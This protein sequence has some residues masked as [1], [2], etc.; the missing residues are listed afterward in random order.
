MSDTVNSLSDLRAEGAEL[1]L[2]PRL[3]TQPRRCASRKLDK[4]GRAYATGKRKD[5][6]ARVWLKPGTGKITVNGRDQEVY[7]AR[8]VLR[9]IINQPFQV[10]DREGQYDVV[11]RSRAAASPVRPVRCARHLEGADQLRARSCARGQEGRLPDPRQPRRRAQEVRQGEG[12]PQ[13]PVLEALANGPSTISPS[14][15]AIMPM[16]PCGSW[17][18]CGSASR[19]RMI[20]S[21]PWHCTTGASAYAARMKS[22]AA[23]AWIEVES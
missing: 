8:P 16:P 2:R 5:A 12:P 9:M 17:A 22:S 4:Q 18:G 1:R 21:I 14:T 10:A 15:G 7:F 20:F 23:C 13:L 6:V 11:A 19:R 3:A